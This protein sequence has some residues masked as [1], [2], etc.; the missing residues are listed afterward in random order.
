MAGTFDAHF[1]LSALGEQ[2]A[3]S[4]GGPYDLAV[5]GGTALNVLGLVTRTTRDIDVFALV[6]HGRLVPCPVMPADLAEAASRVARDFDLSPDWINV[7][8]AV[9][10]PERLPEG[11]QS[12][13]ERREYGTR[14]AAHFIGLLDQIH[15]KLH[16]A[17]DRGDRTTVHFADLQR[18]SPSPEEIR[19]AARWACDTQ[20]PSE[21]FRVLLKECIAALGFKDVSEEF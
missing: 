10:H 21:G 8:A 16:A 18:L 1:F 2:L 13:W 15:F 9:I 7:Q 14:L 6:E 3:Y 12:R 11:L 5:C 17:A 4:G 20:D 19:M